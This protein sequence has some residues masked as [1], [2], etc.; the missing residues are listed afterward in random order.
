MAARGQDAEELLL[1]IHQL[2]E[3]IKAADISGLEEA[4]KL[5]PAEQEILE[6]LE[7]SGY[8]SFGDDEENKPGE[9][10]FFFVSAITQTEH[11]Q[12]TADAY[13]RAKAQAERLA[14]AAGATLGPLKS[15]ASEVSKAEN[16]SQYDPYR[17][18]DLDPY[19]S[20]F[21]TTPPAGNNE[22]PEAI[23]TKPGKVT[24]RVQVSA[25]FTLK[26]Q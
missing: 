10:T 21:T 25:S 19:V 16:L 6:E 14:K 1:E 4:S 15:L 23:G 2:Q 26:E 18:F 12:A 17:L 11:D 20:S 5:S 9:P 22:T 7:D 3:K 24:Y 8:S 13:K